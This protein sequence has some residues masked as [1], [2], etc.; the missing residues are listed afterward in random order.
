MANAGELAIDS[1]MQCGVGPCFVSAALILAGVTDCATICSPSSANW[2]FLRQMEYEEGTQVINQLPVR[3][4]QATRRLFDVAFVN[5]ATAGTIAA[6]L[7]TA[8]SMLPGVGVVLGFLFVVVVVALCY[9]DGSL[10]KIGFRK[11]ES[12]I[13]TIA[14]GAVIGVVAQLIF[15]VVIDPLLGRLTGEAV[16]VSAWDWVRGDVRNYLI[17][18]AIGWGVGG[19]LEEILF[20]GYL[21]GRLRYVLGGNRVAIVLAIVLPALAFGMAHRYQ[22]AAGMISTGLLG[23]LFGGAFVWYRGNLWLPILVHGFAN[24]VGITFIY[25]SADLV[26]NTLLFD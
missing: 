5:R 17:M 26:L 6:V 22:G 12:W 15:T 25:T 14:L 3:L 11:P 13:R 4:R 10:A 19:L 21:L 1:D 23:A 20:R 24:A 8:A 18:L 16:D 7:L 2:R 9:P